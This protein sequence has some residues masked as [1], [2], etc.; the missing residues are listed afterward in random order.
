MD[1][2]IAQLLSQTDIPIWGACRFDPADLSVPCRAVSR[3]PDGAKTVFV[4]AFPYLL[5][6]YERGRNLSRYA[7]VR[8]YHPVAKQALEQA[9]Q[10]LQEA[11]P[12]ERFAAFADISPF[13][14]VHIA[15]KAGLGVIGRNS[16]LLHPVYGSWLFLGEIVSTLEAGA[17]DSPV[18][19]CAGCGA[20]ERACPGG[21]LCE[22]KLEETRCI[23]AIT[24]KKGE[25]S[26]EEQALIRRGGLVWGCDVCQSV[27]PMNRR[28]LV[29]PYPPFLQDVVQSVEEETAPALCKARAFGFRGA[30]VIKR[31]LGILRGKGGNTTG[32]SNQ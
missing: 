18:K 23:S 13:D 20:C 29:K 22:G 7:C 2:K 3:V 10:L 21:A 31:N 25:L 8:D 24:Q 6:E 26:E 4:F 12:G 11:F 5:G 1:G 30:A 15:A 19:G 16:L 14:E 27:C 28:A 32:E 17:V 9:A